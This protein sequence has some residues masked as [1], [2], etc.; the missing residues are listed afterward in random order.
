MVAFGGLG[1]VAPSV[2]KFHY[3]SLLPA[4]GGGLRFK[5]SKKYDVNLRADI[6]QGAGL[7]KHDLASRGLVVMA[8]IIIDQVLLPRLQ[9]RVGFPDLLI[10]VLLFR[11]VGRLF[12]WVWLRLADCQIRRHKYRQND[13]E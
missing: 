7:I 1:E 13:Y 4:G 2:S 6:A 10:A 5:L 9:F 8:D 3:Q 11:W 12:L